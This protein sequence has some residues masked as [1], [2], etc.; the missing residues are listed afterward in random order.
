V[1]TKNALFLALFLAACGGPEIEDEHFDETEST[2][3]LSATSPVPGRGITTPFGKPGSLWAAGYHTGDDY[4]APTGTRVVATRGGRVVFAGWGGFG[5]AYGRH[6]IVE[7]SGIRH[8]YAHLSGTSVST[9]QQVSLGQKL[10][11]VGATGNVTGPHLH[12]EERHSPYGYYDH[13]RPVFNKTAPASAPAPSRRGFK[14]WLYGTSHSDIRGLQRAMVSAGCSVG[15]TF[16]DHYGDQTKS[17]VACFQRKQGWSG[18]DADG[19]VGPVTAERAWLVGDVYVDRLHSG[20][21]NSD[22]VR[23]LQQRLNEVRGSS[24]RITGDYDSTTKS[25]VAAWQRS[26]GDSGVGADGNMGPRQSERLF[27]GH[28]YVLH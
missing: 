9:G 25:A 23:M 14:N 7:T 6:V 2:D 19:I 27:P 10:G 11:E 17:A 20:V 28:R 1:N 4:S 18:S 3:A 12:Y 8:L 22:S 26:I 16:T 15:G 5:A 21:N 13:R 24:L